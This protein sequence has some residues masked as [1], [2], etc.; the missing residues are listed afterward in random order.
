VKVCATS[1]V[2]HTSLQDAAHEKK[3]KRVRVLSS[4]LVGYMSCSLVLSLSLSR[5]LFF[6]MYNYYMEGQLVKTG[7]KQK[8][9]KRAISIHLIRIIV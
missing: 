7:M 1:D 9:R 2:T 4:S 8:E 3:R 6:S 5:S